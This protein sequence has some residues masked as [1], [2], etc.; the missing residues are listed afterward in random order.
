M[1]RRDITL[2]ETNLYDIA[3]RIVIAS[4]IE[5]ATTADLVLKRTNLFIAVLEALESRELLTAETIAEIL[6]TRRP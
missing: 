4:R 3:E 2:S 5:A 6:G 1:D